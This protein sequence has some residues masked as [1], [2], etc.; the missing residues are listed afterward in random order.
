M[1]W[2]DIRCANLPGLVVLLIFFFFLILALQLMFPNLVKLFF[3][4]PFKFCNKNSEILSSFSGL[5]W[6]YFTA[7][8]YISHKDLSQS[9]LPSLLQ[10]SDPE[11]RDMH[12]T[13]FPWLGPWAWVLGVCWFKRCYQNVLTVTNNTQSLGEF[14]MLF[15][16][17]SSA[18]L[19]L[20]SL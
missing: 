13:L 7:M 10:R 18:V 3:F 1:W 2:C 17:T 4:F 14:K 6:H 5:C 20:L 16:F 8:N 15:I 11:N 9:F 12:I 19:I